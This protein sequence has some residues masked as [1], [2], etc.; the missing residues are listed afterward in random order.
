[1]VRGGG[2]ADAQCPASSRSIKR[3]RGEKARLSVRALR[4]CEFSPTPPHTP[5]K[6]TTL[7]SLNLSGGAG[8]V[9]A[10][11]GRGLGARVLTQHNASPLVFHVG[12]CGVCEEARGGVWRGV[13]GGD[14][15]MH[16][17]KQSV[18]FAQDGRATKQFRA[19]E[20]IQ[21]VWSHAWGSAGTRMTKRAVG[22]ER[23]VRWDWRLDSP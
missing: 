20:D 2:C 4:A 16:G 10:L 23:A 22:E 8:V 14:A 19:T 1:M 9:H 17:G 11:V 13:C 21:V 6:L 12:L 3:R 15:Y 5:A 18:A 7:D